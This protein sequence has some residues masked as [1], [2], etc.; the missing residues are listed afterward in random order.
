MKR[1]E[2]CFALR[3]SATVGPSA[4]YHHH[5]PRTRWQ[6]RAGDHSRAAGD[7]VGEWLGRPTRLR[8]TLHTAASCRTTGSLCRPPLSGRC[9]SPL[10]PHGANP[11]A[12]L[13]PVYHACRYLWPQR[14]RPGR[15]PLW[16]A[17]SSHRCRSW[18]RRHLA[19]AGVLHSYHGGSGG[20]GDR[21]GGRAPS[22]C[23]LPSPAA[24]YRRSRSRH[25]GRGGDQALPLPH[26][27]ASRCVCRRCEWH[28][29]PRPRRVGRR[30]QRGRRGRLAWGG[31]LCR[32]PVGRRRRRERLPVRLA[33]RR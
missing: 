31:L 33:E 6:L 20:G 24:L 1:N 7:R 10:P 18:R 25:G 17:S 30:P 28:G 8:T 19:V 27:T 21:D 3:H 5:Y 29:R 23:P 12:R 16:A 4:Q 26:S 15:P 22:S 9:P 2:A 32:H 11:L 13:P 14:V